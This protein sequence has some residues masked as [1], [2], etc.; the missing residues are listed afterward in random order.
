[1]RPRHCGQIDGFAVLVYHTR[2][3]VSLIVSEAVLDTDNDPVVQVSVGVERDTN[4]FSSTYHKF[5]KTTPK[6]SAI[7]KSSGE[8][9]GPPPPVP[10]VAVDVALGA[11]EVEDEVVAMV[12][13]RECYEIRKVTCE[14][15]RSCDKYLDAIDTRDETGRHS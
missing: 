2:L 11:A 3:A 15:R 8:L 7:K 13:S 4:R 10:C 6:P 9:V 12:V 14:S 5:V 1:M